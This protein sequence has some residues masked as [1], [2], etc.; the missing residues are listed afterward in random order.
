MG[1]HA[2]SVFSFVG[3]ATEIEASA[4]GTAVAQ[5]VDGVVDAAE[6][7]GF[8]LEIVGNCRIG[9]HL[10][11]LDGV[12]P[13]VGNQFDVVPLAPERRLQGAEGVDLRTTAGGN[14]RCFDEEL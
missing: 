10:D 14:K 6:V 11:V 12:A 3:A 13:L 7:W 4:F 1:A 5:S 2:S 8:D 9:K